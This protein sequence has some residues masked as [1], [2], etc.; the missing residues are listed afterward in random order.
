MRLSKRKG[1][2]A[3]ATVAAVMS[4]GLGTADASH[5]HFIYQPEHGNHPATCRWI[6]DGQTSKAPGEPGGHAFHNHVHTGQPG[7]DDRGTDFDKAGN[8]GNYDCVWVN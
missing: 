7:V 4:L 3:V 6:A 8:E 1:A 2:V 5:E